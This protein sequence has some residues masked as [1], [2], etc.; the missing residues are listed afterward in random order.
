MNAGDTGQ[1]GVG[2][3]LNL[4]YSPQRVQNRVPRIGDRG[5]VERRGAVLRVETGERP[6]PVRAVHRVAATAAVKVGVD[7]TG[8]QV[9]TARVGSASSLVRV[10]PNSSRP[11]TTPCGNTRRPSKRVI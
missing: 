3:G 9:G 6:Y 4:F 8:E 1:G 10:S 11:A 5:R 2:V 7:K